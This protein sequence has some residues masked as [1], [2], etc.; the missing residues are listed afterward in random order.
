MEKKFKK[1]PH[2]NYEIEIIISPAEQEEA[3]ATILKHFQKDF[4]MAGFRKGMAPLETVEKNTKPEYIQMGIYEHLIN[5]WL[6][7]LIKDNAELKLIGEPYDFKQEKKGDDTVMTMKLDIF[8]EVE[9]LNDDWQK[10]QL[11]EIK[12]AATQEEIDN[13]LVSLKKNY[14]DY[15][16][17]DIIT[18]ET[19]SK[20]EMEFLDTDG[21]TLDKGHNYVGEQEF[22]E[23]KRYEKEFMGKKKGDTREV[24]YSEKLPPVYHYK[25]TEGEAKKVKILV[26]DVKK[27]VLPEMDEVM[28]QKLFGPESTVKNEAQLLDFITESISHQKFEAELVKVV[29]WLL[30]KVKGK[31]MNVAI[32]QTLVEQEFAT[33]MKSLVER[34]GGEEKMTEYFKK[35]WEEQGKKFLDDIKTAAADSLEKFFILQ[36]IVETLKLD[37][38]REKPGHLEIEQK[39][40]ERMGKWHDHH[41]HD[42][43]HESHPVQENIAHHHENQEHDFKEKKAPKAKKPAAKK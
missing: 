40:Y 43:Q 41:H 19:I 7:E 12:S 3:K 29:E 23:D 18:H 9:V 6:Q 30:Q 5:K 36:K 26:Q 33:R 2:A 39:L 42:H 32:P 16:D 27:I 14:A 10:E 28:L 35:L 31:H 22:A 11:A 20:V 17:T 4:E 38:N 25:K 34:F 13:A 24:A 37:V 21:K 1:G 15:Q 8:P